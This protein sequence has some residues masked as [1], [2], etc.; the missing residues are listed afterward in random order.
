MVTGCFC[1]FIT[2]P[3]FAHFSWIRDRAHGLIDYDYGIM[4]F[5]YALISVC[6]PI[7]F[8][9]YTDADT[10][11][12]L[13]EIKKI[14]AFTEVWR[15]VD[16]Q[17]LFDPLTRE[18]LAFQGSKIIYTEV[19]PSCA[20]I[21]EYEELEGEELPGSGGLSARQ[22][23]RVIYFLKSNGNFSLS[24]TQ[25]VGNCQYAAV[26]RG[27][28]LKREVTSMHIRR[29]MVMEMCKKPLF[30]YHYLHRS[31]CTHYGFTRLTQEELASGDYTQQ[32]LADQRLP[33]PFSF[34]SY[35]QHLLTDRTWGDI[36]TLTILSCLWQVGITIVFTDHLNEHRIRHDK[37]LQDA[38]LVVVFTGG[39]HYLG[40][41]EYGLIKSKYGNVNTGY[42]MIIFACG[43]IHIQ[44]HSLP[45]DVVVSISGPVVNLNLRWIR[46]D[47]G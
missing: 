18:G 16:M 1:R 11:A 8:T 20:E 26:Q 38:D 25:D 7:D 5:G 24:Q 6:A 40:C 10:R 2:K 4:K 47:T 42:G 13:A 23:A 28:Q 31:I 41:G 27:T 15:L 30:W 14:P 34:H 45:Y 35:L 17:G 46:V 12:A 21:K 22:M 39:N 9:L 33:G 36:H 19:D 29:F 37:R 44:R 43:I 32:T 3:L